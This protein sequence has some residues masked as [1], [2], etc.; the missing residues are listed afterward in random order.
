MGNTVGKDGTH[1]WGFSQLWF[2]RARKNLMEPTYPAFDGLTES[3]IKITH[4]ELEGFPEGRKEREIPVPKQH[5]DSMNMGMYE[6][7]FCADKAILHKRC[8][9]HN[10]PFTNWCSR[11]W[12]HYE[13]CLADDFRLRMKEFERERRLNARKARIEKNEQIAEARARMEALK[14]EDDD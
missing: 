7:N 2:E 3:G 4:D 1:D 5:M 11:E 14:E 13:H 9:M 6:R 12:H 8:T 10:W